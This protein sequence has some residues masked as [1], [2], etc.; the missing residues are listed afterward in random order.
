M[1]GAQARPAMNRMP[2]TPTFNARLGA[3]QVD[4]SAADL[5]RLVATVRRYFT[6]TRREDLEPAAAKR[7]GE[8]PNG[9]AVGR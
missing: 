6:G 3:I 9:E 1:N 4:P 7:D 2:K 5:A 8:L